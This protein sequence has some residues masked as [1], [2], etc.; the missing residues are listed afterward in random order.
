MY[1]NL[2]NHLGSHGYLS[3]VQY[4]ALTNKAVMNIFVYMFWTRM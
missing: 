3:C 1:R 2:Y 4:F